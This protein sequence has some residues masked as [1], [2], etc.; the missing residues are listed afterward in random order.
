MKRH[1]R[2]YLQALQAFSRPARELVQVT[3]AADGQF[4]FDFEADD[5]LYRYWNATAAV[6]FGFAMAEQALDVELRHETL[7]LARFDQ[8]RRAVDE[9]HDIRGSLLAT[10]ITVALDGA[11]TI[12]SNKRKRYAGAL[13]PEMFD[14]IEEATRAVL[15]QE[16][17]SEPD[18]P[19]AAR[20]RG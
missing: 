19:V 14:A 8:I 9:Q 15:L 18:P 3:S 1:E 10:L 20:E 12:S 7:Y 16:S 5:T 4:Y 11:G 6:E 2:Q 13:R 17:E